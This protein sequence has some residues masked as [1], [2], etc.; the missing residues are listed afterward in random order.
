MKLA[1]AVR[2]A[3]SVKISHAQNFARHVVPEV[4]RPARVIW[5]RAMGAMFVV[6]AVP[7]IFKAVEVYPGLATDPKAAFAFGISLIFAAVMA[8]FAVNSFLKASRVS[9]R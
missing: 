7:A 4:V 3:R 8:L 2:L 1:E 6:L 9:R 5:N